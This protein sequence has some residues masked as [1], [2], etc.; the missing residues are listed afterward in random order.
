MGSD[1][2]ERIEAK[3]KSTLRK[4]RLTSDSQHGQKKQHEREHK[5]FGFGQRSRLFGLVG[6]FF[7]R[8]SAGV[9]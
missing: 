1:R 2:G 3:E 6:I 8:A 9:S 4:Q 7:G 5:E